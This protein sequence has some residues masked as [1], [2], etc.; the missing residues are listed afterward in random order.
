MT[1]IAEYTTEWLLFPA[2]SSDA[3]FIAVTIKDKFQYLS[4]KDTGF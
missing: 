1:I 2:P 4:K 3:E